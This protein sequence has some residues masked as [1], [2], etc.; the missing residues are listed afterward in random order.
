MSSLRQR[1]RSVLPIVLAVSVIALSGAAAAALTATAANATN[2]NYNC[3]SD[4]FGSTCEAAVGSDNWVTNNYAIDYTNNNVCSAIQQYGGGYVKYCSG[5][6]AYSELVC[7][8]PQVYGFGGSNNYY[9]YT[10][11]LAGNENNYQNCTQ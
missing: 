8:Y 2:Q 4:G 3:S 10:D 1:L 11:N 5:N 7:D 6:S 9:L